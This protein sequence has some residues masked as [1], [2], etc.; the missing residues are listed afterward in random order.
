MD[1][2]TRFSTINKTPHGHHNI[3]TRFSTI[4]KTPHGHHN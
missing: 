3:I 1:I 2:I 4:N